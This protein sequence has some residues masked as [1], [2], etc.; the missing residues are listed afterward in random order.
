MN[1]QPPEII[2]IGEILRAARVAK[3][4]NQQTLAR[5]LRMPVHLVA[6]IEGEDW[7]RVPPG[8]ERPLARRIASHLQVDLSQHSQ[9]WELMPGGPPMEAPDPRRER[10][11]QILMGAL[12]LGSVA[13]FLWL[14]VPGRDIKGNIPQRE[15]RKGFTPAAVWV[16]TSPP[17]PYPVLGEVLP[18]AP[19]NAEGIL[20]N[21]RAMDACGARVAGEGVDLA[22]ALQVS[23]PWTLRVKGRFTLTLDNAGVVTVEVAGRR[24]NHGGAVGEPWS[25]QFDEEG[26][27]LLP[28]A[29]APTLP[30]HVP[31]TD[32][33]APP[34]D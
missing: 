6:A 27:W 8:R 24:I 2:G 5:E 20:L 22:H 15:S 21:L 10:M 34:E 12:S 4:L 25:G 26:R 16:P 23:E 30:L 19:V 28:P 14:V 31:Q 1:A 29:A 13:L 17:A 3:G 33:E 32:P 11:E 7:P 18:E 9:V